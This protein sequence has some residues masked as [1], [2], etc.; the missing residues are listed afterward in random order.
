MNKL[1]N[2]INRPVTTL[3]SLL[4]A[5]GGVTLVELMI[6]VAIIGIV[7]A[8]SSNYLVNITRFFR[9]SQARIE[10]QRDARR[11]I[12]L[13]NR[14]MRQ[15]SASTVTIKSYNS[16]QPPWSMIEFTDIKGTQ[17]K[18][19]QLGTKFYMSVKKTTDPSFKTQAIAE[20]LR[21]LIFAYPRFDNDKIISVSICF[22]K[23]TY[24][25][26]AKALQMSVE[27]VR[28]MNN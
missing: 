28:I 4:A 10:I 3:H 16:S 23:T 22:E 24:E 13:I 12:D 1:L 6:V 5:C 9:L 7:S 17:W 18:F 2:Y 15:A 14:N 8:V 25:G 19:Y 26:R 21:S 27:K 11:C 20:N